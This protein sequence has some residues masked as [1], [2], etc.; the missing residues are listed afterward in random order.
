MIRVEAHPAPVDAHAAE[1]DE[2][3]VFG[4][5]VYILTDCVLFASLFATYVVLHGNTAGGPSGHQ[6]FEMPYVLAETMALLASSFTCGL[7]MLAAVRGRTRLAVVALA[8][9]FALGS[10]FLALELSEFHHLAVIGA[11]WSRSGFLSAYFILVGTHGLHITVGLLWMAVVAARIWWSGLGRGE[12][13][14]LTLFGIFWHFLDLVWIF[15]F[16]VVYLM[17]AAHL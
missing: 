2:R 15:I 12:L 5:W 11:G 13:R 17:G 9:T 14:R 7:A 16:S 10:T 8:L 6:L 1:A 4:F 3:T